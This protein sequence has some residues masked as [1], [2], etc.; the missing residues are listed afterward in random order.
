M[1]PACSSLLATIHQGQCLPAQ[2]SIGSGNACLSENADMS[3]NC[4]SDAGAVAKVNA[5]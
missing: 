4:S 5:Q 3:G 2:Y 1:F